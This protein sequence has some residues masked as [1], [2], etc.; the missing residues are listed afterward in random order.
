MVNKVVVNLN[1]EVD[2][3]GSI[4]ILG[5]PAFVPGDEVVS[6][7]GMDVKALYDPSGNG[8]LI[9][10]WEPSDDLNNIKCC[11]AVDDISGI[12]GGVIAGAGTAMSKALAYEMQKVLSSAFDASGVAPFK[13]AFTTVKQDYIHRDFGRLVLATYAADL[14]GHPAATAAVTNDTTILKSML[15][16][17]DGIADS[18]NGETGVTARFNSWLQKAMVDGSGYSEWSTA[19]AFDEVVGANLAVR[20]V[21]K[22]LDKD[23]TIKVNQATASN[24]ALAYIVQ[25]VLGQDASRA[26][27][28]DNNALLPDYHQYLKFYNGDVI[29]VNI[30]VNKPTVTFGPGQLST[31]DSTVSHNFLVKIELKDT[32]VPQ[33]A[34]ADFG[35]QA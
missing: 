2:A 6:L 3:S 18:H 30:V 21:K 28:V 29:Y 23:A 24:D 32:V 7:R 12:D 33:L 5:E 4:T 19:S 8:G 22:I 31:T 15:S 11:I 26:M 25:Q 13:G 20:L 1:V 10:F 14:L 27:G 9:E 34:T 35:T 17:S 16:V